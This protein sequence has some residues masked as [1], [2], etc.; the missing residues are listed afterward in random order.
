[1]NTRLAPPQLGDHILIVLDLDPTFDQALRTAIAQIPHID[2]PLFTLLCCLPVHYWEHG[3]ADNPDVV[4][5]I[6]KAWNE[7]EEEQDDAEFYLDQAN[8]ILK[9]AGVPE[10]HIVKTVSSNEDSVISAVMHELKQGFY[11][12]VILSQQHE[13]IVNRLMRRGITDTLRHIPHVGV[14][15]L[16]L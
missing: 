14:M 3:G 13:D 12:G 8:A 10:T 9:Q 4:H 2:Q 5:Q 15:T 11:S 7:E 16:D 6:K 1:M